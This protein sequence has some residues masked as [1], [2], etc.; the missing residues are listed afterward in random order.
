M[1][2]RTLQAS[3][4]VRYPHCHRWG[5]LSVAM[6]GPVAMIETLRAIADVRVPGVRGNRWAADAQSAKAH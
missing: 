2:A 6:P 3:D 5:L 1:D 4:E